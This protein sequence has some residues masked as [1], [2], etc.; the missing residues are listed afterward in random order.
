M[1]WILLNRLSLGCLATEPQHLSPCLH[2][3][4][5]ITSVRRH[6]G[7]FHVVLGLDTMTST[8]SVPAIFQKC[9]VDSGLFVQQL[10]CSPLPS[11]LSPGLVSILRGRE[12]QHERLPWIV[13]GCLQPCQQSR[14]LL[15]DGGAHPVSSHQGQQDS[16][17]GV[18][19]LTFNLRQARIT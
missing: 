6:S 18:I 17:L 2:L 9:G 16:S 19:M 3:L 7:L 4:T 15:K 8:H 12:R 13:A 14:P 5:G 1:A 10:L 11:V